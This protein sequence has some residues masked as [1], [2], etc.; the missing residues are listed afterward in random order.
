[1]K[2]INMDETAK[3]ELK[4]KIIEEQMAKFWDFCSKV[5]QTYHRND[6]DRVIPNSV[7]EF[8]SLFLNKLTE[9]VKAI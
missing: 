1:M 4:R 9:M 3:L 7:Q 8:S 2:A 5:M 6:D